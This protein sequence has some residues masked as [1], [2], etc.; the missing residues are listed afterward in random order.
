M[1]QFISIQKLYELFLA[2]HQKITTDTRKIQPGSIFFALK[3]DNFDANEF[4]EKAIELGCSYVVVDDAS[5]PNGINILFVFNVLETLQELARFHR[6]QLAY[7]IIAITGSNGKTTNKELIA[8]VLSKKYNTLATI[9]NLNNHIGVPLTLLSLTQEHQI[10]I[11][12]MGANH[13][14]EI[15]FLCSLADPDFGIITNIGLA[16]LEGFGGV[17]GVK[18]GKSEMY[19]WLINKSGKVFING[20][21]A[22]LMELSKNLDKI[23]YGTQN[24]F[25]V[26]GE[27]I[28]SNEFVTFKWNTKNKNTDTQPM[29]KT[30]MFG[31]YN[32]INFL[33]AIC[34][35]NYFQVSETDINSAL[36]NYVPEMNRSQVKKT[37]LNSIIL[38]AYNANPSSMSLAIQNFSE[39]DFV[40]KCVII[41]D[42]FELGDYSE[43]EHL[44]VL[45]QILKSD[46]DLTILVGLHFIRFKDQFLNFKFFESV[47]DLKEYLTLSIVKDFTILIKGSRG[48]QLEKIVEIL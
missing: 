40:K 41:G 11:I 21:D 42:M 23:C 37:K 36:E 3:G 32:F 39:Q 2:C 48:M 27:L 46:F 25:D 5:K 31:H 17:E 44:K 7:P 33:C 29:V 35:G 45:Q 20:D 19:K 14:G 38:D 6:K 10:G 15:D 30:Q 4:S 34:I 13:C 26:H 18:R 47:S 9:G 12:E 28:N 1:S 22:V 43:T 16:H 8:A 24:I